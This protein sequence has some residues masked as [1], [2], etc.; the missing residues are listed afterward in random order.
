[1][2][3]SDWD[4]KD[5]AS[6]QESSNTAIFRGPDGQMLY[7]FF[8][9]GS[10]LGRW[11]NIMRRTRSDCSGFS[12]DTPQLITGVQGNVVVWGYSGKHE[13]DVRNDITVDDLRWLAPQ[14]SAITPDQI[15]A[16]LKASGATDRQNASWTESLES[17]I[18]EVEAVARTGQYYR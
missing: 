7:S 3:L 17:R 10:T 18:H 6:G 12:A 2:M 1:M 4:A 8:D 9:W 16:G 15:R 11:G 5:L 14:L 13:D